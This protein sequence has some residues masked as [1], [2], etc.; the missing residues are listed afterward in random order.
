MSSVRYALFE[1]LLPRLGFHEEKDQQHE[2]ENDGVEGE[3]ERPSD[4]HIQGYTD[5]RPTKKG[6][7]RGGS[8][9]ISRSVSGDVVPRHPEETDRRQASREI[10][11]PH[12]GHSFKEGVCL[13]R[14]TTSVRDAAYDNS[15]TQYQQA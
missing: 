11:I 9:I 2:R 15:L 5:E 7:G 4:S 12:P 13:D 14:S 10:M 6:R 1:S 8:V 3:R